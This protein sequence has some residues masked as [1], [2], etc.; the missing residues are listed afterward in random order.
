[1]SNMDTESWQYLLDKYLQNSISKEELE[2]LLQKASEY[3]DLETFSTALK[4]HWEKA[5]EKAFVGVGPENWDEKFAAMMEEAK[6]SAPAIKMQ[7]KKGTRW[8]YRIVAAASVLILLSAGTYFLFFHKPTKEISQAKNIPQ[9]KNDVAAPTGAKTTLTLANGS[10]IILDSAQNGALADQGNSRVQKLNSSQ[11]AYNT[12]NEKPTEIVYNTLT[13][14]KGGQTMVVLADGTKVWLNALS[15]LKF[16]TAFAGEN[17]E[18][19][20]KGEGYFEVSKNARMPFYV[21]VNDVRVKVLGTHF[22]IMAYD[23]ENV[24]K[25]TL[26]EGSVKITKD[27]KEKILKP[28]EQATVDKT[29]GNVQVKT[30]EDADEAIAWKNGFFEFSRLDMQGI[31]RQV[32]RWYDVEVSYDQKVN[33]NRTFS[34]IVSRSS[35][36]SVVMKIMEQANIHF[37]VEGNKIIITE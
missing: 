26:L 20:L 27:T 12:L 14:A 3:E 19:E 8:L 9:L 13:T 5:K 37:K 24:I 25:T 28:G 11:L 32:S 36:L 15:S 7:D 17:R 34:A 10:T 1:M 18:V 2:T 21:K 29:N 33:T 6:R 35:N 30:D 31:M 23:D 16:P 4:S 22:N